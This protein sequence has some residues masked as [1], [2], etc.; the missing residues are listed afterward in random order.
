MNVQTKFNKGI[1]DRRLFED[2]LKTVY[3]EF[4]ASECKV[5]RNALIQTSLYKAYIS[6][7]SVNTMSID[8]IKDFQNE[9]INYAKERKQEIKQDE[10]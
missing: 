9:I 6:P 10:L 2:H 4:L 7:K 3:A 8:E 5:Y 1:F